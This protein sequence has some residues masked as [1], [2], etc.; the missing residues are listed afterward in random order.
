MRDIEYVDA[1]GRRGRYSGEVDGAGLPCGYGVMTY[2]D[3]TRREGCWKNGRRKRPKEER[4]RPDP[5]KNR[6]F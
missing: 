4:R 2:E 1:K 5:S 6:Y 3:G